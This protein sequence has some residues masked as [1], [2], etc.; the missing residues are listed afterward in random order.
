[1]TALLSIPASPGKLIIDAGPFQV[2]WYGLLIALG[3]FLADLIIRQLPLRRSSLQAAAQT[4]SFA[5]RRGIP[6]R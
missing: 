5:R 6:G 3:L 1:M 2:R 4:M